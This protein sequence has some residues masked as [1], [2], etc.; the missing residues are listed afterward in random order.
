[1]TSALLSTATRYFQT[2]SHPASIEEL[3][4]VEYLYAQSG[5]KFNTD[6]SGLDDQIDEGFDDFVEDAPIDHLV[7]SVQ[8]YLTVATPAESDTEGGGEGG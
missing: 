3:F 4:G 7:D 6:E 8:D 2:T 1:M 5:L